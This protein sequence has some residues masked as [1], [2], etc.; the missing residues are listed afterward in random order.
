MPRTT[1]PPIA[2][3]PEVIAQARWRRG[4]LGRL[5]VRFGTLFAFFLLVLVIPLAASF[6]SVRAE[7]GLALGRARIVQAIVIGS[8]PSA[9]FNRTCSLT[10][11]H[12]AWTGPPAPRAGSFSVCDNDVARY[13][14]GAAVRVAALPGDSSVT[15]GESR[16]SAIGG[17]VI[18]S[19]FL[20]IWLLFVGGTGWAA[21]VAVTAAR[22]WRRAPWL[23]GLVRPGDAAR[24]RGRGAGQ[25]VTIFLDAGSVPWDPAGDRRGTS[26]SGS[27]SY[28]TDAW[29]E[30]SGLSRSTAASVLVLP[31]RDRSRLQQGD[32]VWLVPAGLTL[33]RRYRTSPYA[34]IRADDSRVFWGTGRRLPGRGW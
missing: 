26:L 13:P 3:R 33:L 14:L 12:V 16:G 19:V 7:W 4:G 1:E 27:R 29:A 24:G 30:E 6:G 23:P 10:D 17:A 11:I 25:R 34:V 8:S 32:R 31:R 20:L 9:Q 18:E 15:A 22:R 2:P 21:L 28:A 5:Q